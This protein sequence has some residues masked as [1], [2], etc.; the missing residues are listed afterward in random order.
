MIRRLWVAAA[1]LALLSGGAAADQ[2]APLA[3]GATAPDT[4]LVDQS[5]HSLRLADLIKQRDF[6]VVAFYVKAFTGG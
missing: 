5:G 6:V 2:Q 3:V 4:T 1:V